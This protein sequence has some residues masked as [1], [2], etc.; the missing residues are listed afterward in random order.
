MLQENYTEQIKDVF[1][2]L[3][4]VNF[5]S[6]ISRTKSGE[7]RMINLSLF[8]SFVS[9]MVTSAYY[10]GSEDAMKSFEEAVETTFK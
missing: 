4:I 6:E 1:E 9:K 3:P 8:E 10:Q 7:I 5:G 2:K